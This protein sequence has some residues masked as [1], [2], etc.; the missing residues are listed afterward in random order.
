MK[1]L[2]AYATKEL[3]QDAFLRWLFE[4]YDCENEKV[5]EVCEKLFKAFTQKELDFS[6]IDKDSLR[7]VAQWKNI[8]VSIWFSIQGK[9]Y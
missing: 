2:F 3:S 6:K 4:N 5:R 7:T 1:N 9:Q 8:D